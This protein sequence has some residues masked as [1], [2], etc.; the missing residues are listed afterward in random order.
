M[1][2][3][4]SLIMFVFCLTVSAQNLK[5]MTY[6]IRLALD[7]DK[8]NSWENRKTDALKL[9]NYYHPDVLGVQEAVPEQMSDLKNG[10]TGYDFVGVGRDDGSN[11]G[12]YSAIF[13]DTA[14][15]NFCNPGLSGSAKLLKNLLK[16]GMQLTTGSAHLPF[17]KL[18]KAAEISGLSMYISIM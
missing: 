3:L 7:S 8:E 6:N 10:L 4:I 18:K 2:R 9:L 14:K 12:E 13:F 1:K 5:V 11:N 15:L 17:L 16:G